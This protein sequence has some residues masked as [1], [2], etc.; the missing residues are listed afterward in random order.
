MLL[1]RRLED[2][3]FWTPDYEIRGQAGRRI[4]ERG[5]NP[6][7]IVND[8]SHGVKFW[9]LGRPG[10]VVE[11]RRGLRYATRGLAGVEVESI[12]VYV[13]ILIYCFKE[14]GFEN[15]GFREGG[16]LKAEGEG[17]LGLGGNL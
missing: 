9:G 6:S 15:E 10:S 14:L 2:T 17:F 1:P 5:G 13:Y 16:Y 12:L 3:K 8:T 4:A 7:E 11:L